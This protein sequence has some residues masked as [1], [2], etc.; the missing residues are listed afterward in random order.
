MQI[1]IIDLGTNTFNL[2]I[3]EVNENNQYTIILEDKYPSKIG[4]G[5]INKNTITPEAFERGF[6]ALE[7]HLNTIAKI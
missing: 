6:K 1:A 5:G 7:T 3:T 2:L 4:K